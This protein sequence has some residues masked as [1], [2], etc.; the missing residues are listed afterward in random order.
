LLWLDN[1][2]LIQLA[3]Q[4]YSMLSPAS[5]PPLETSETPEVKQAKIDVF[6]ILDNLY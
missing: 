6:S 1:K 3:K 2:L 4:W 5:S